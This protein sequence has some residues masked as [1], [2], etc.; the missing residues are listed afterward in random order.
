MCFYREVSEWLRGREKLVII[1]KNT[2]ERR[3]TDVVVTCGGQ[4]K[5]VTVTCRHRANRTMYRL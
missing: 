3:E 5:I 4:N 2:Q 1:K